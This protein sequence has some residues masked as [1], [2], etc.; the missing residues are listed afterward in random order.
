MGYLTGDESEVCACYAQM[1]VFKRAQVMINAHL[2]SMFAVAEPFEP[3]AARPYSFGKQTITDR[4]RA[5]IPIMLRHRLT[6]PP[7]E[8]Y[9]LNR[10]LSG[11]F[12]LCA[13]LGSRIDCVGMLD[14]VVSTMAEERN[15]AARI[16]G[17]DSLL[18]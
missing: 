6:P 4:V 17:D 5:Q 2:E 10:K 15:K 9:S 16:L 18:N 7:T 12:L 11:C 1:T 8:T 13:R 3:S 14:E